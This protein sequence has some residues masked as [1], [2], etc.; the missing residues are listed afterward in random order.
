MK[1]KEQT[2]TGWCKDHKKEI[3]VV[4]VGITAV[5][6]VA[7][8]IKHYGMLERDCS[9]VRKLVEKGPEPIRT[10]AEIPVNE[11]VPEEELGKLTHTIISGKA[12]HDSVKHLRNLSDGRMASAEKIA[13][14]AENGFHLQ[15]HQTWVKAYHT[16]TSSV[17]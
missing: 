15:P 12:P 1:K 3:I 9:S 14:A 11:L 5:V 2:F 7:V 4:G 16:G 13:T 6:V 10:I 17:A 8:G